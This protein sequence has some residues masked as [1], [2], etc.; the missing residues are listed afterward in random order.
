MDTP[1][2][3][4]P[5]PIVWDE[6]REL[7]AMVLLAS[8]VMVVAAPGI[9]F[10][11]VGGPFGF[12]DDVAGILANVN[13]TVGLLLLGSAVL[14]CTVQPVD[15]VPALRRSI[16]VVSAVVAVLGVVALLIELTS[17][18]AR[19]DEAVWIRLQLILRRSA[20]ATLLAGTAA[21]L[22]RRVVPFP[23]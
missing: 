13:P 5:P 15:V 19:P 10:I 17:P 14:V 18:S 9:G 20:P 1:D 22:A 6:A 11:G 23:E 12:W 2:S 4:G 16:L 21:F 7:V 3:G 8:A